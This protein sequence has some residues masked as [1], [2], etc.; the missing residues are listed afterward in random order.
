MNRFSRRQWLQG[1]AGV[2]GAG[3]AARL[4]LMPNTA[5]ARCDWYSPRL[6]A[7]AL[8]LISGLLPLVGALM[9][10]QRATT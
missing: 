7:I 1:M 10:R 4:G 8:I 9:T 6:A 2:A 3:A 5:F